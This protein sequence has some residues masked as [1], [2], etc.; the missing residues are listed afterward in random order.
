MKQVARKITNGNATARR[1]FFGRKLLLSFSAIPLCVPALVIALGYVSFFGVNGVLNRI[2]G[3]DKAFL[4]TTFGVVIAQGFYNF[5]FVLG[6]MNDA[7]ESLP[8]EQINAAKLLGSGKVRTFF[9]VT[10]PC[11]SGSLAAACIPVFIFCFFSFMIILLFS[12]AGKSTLEVE[13]YHSIRNTLN[14]KE[15][16]YLSLMETLTTLALVFI[17]AIV[18]KK[19]QTAPC[20]INFADKKKKLSIIDLFVFIPILFFVV[21]FFICPLLCVFTSGKNAFLS[22]FSLS[23]FWQACFSSLWTGFLTAFFCTAIGFLY[24]LVIRL[25]KKQGNILFQ[26][27]PFIPMAISSVAISWVASV[28]FRT[29]NPLVLILLQTFLYWP[30]AY[31]Q[32]QSGMNQLSYETQNA[33]AILSKN[34]FQSIFRVYLPSC[35]K[36]LASSFGF[37]FA[38]SLGDATMPLILSIKK[39]NTLA[40]YTYRLAGSYRFSAACACG[41]I[42]AL[43]SALIFG[44]FKK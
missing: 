35:R 34:I 11:L 21:L 10:L 2:F 7:I 13:L 5:P 39:F 29:S 6:I 12:P 36:N 14:F 17:Y 24:S 28:I 4:Y 40:L 8:K 37:C 33:A 18:I 26:T 20:G 1:N 43:L 31:R 32:I 38:A 41:A 30:I 42:V 19:N 16:F 3:T 25:F 44:G 23:S 22:L 27:I 9:T 15:G